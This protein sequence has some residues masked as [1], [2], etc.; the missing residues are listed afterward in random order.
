ML[1]HVTDPRLG[2]LLQTPRGDDPTCVTHFSISLIGIFALHHDWKSSGRLPSKL[3]SRRGAPANDR[4]RA[5]S[6]TPRIMRNLAKAQTRTRSRDRR[7][8]GPFIKVVWFVD[9]MA[10]TREAKT[11]N[12]ERSQNVV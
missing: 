11:Q 6:P 4:G 5:C 2:R 9:G 7:I 10:K 12:E 8:A 1:L 3:F